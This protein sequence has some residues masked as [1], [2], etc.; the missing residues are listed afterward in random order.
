MNWIL[1][2]IVIAV[3]LLTVGLGMRRGF[4]K[5]V[6]RL[7]SG[8]LALLVASWVAG[9]VAEGIFSAAIENSLTETIETAITQTVEG[10]TQSIEQALGNWYAEQGES[11]RSLLGVCGIDEQSFD[12]MS[13]LTEGLSTADSAQKIVQDVLRPAIV[14]ILSLICTLVIFLIVSVALSFAV[15]LI[16]GV[17]KLPVLRQ[18]NGLLGAVVGLVEGVLIACVVCSA[19]G[20]VAHSSGA[21]AVIS[22]AVMEETVLVQ[23]RDFSEQVLDIDLEELLQ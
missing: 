10:G 5:S 9:P 3:I 11:T 21:D 16:D 15:R 17:L 19:L 13:Q 20:F 7:I 8:I 18:L 4:F 2:I 12:L 6:M 22:P 14:A 1:D 23:H